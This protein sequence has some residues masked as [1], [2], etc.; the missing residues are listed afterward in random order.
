MGTFWSQTE[1]NS[2]MVSSAQSGWNTTATRRTCVRNS[3]IHIIHCLLQKENKWT[4]MS[5]CGRKV[6]EHETIVIILIKILIVIQYL[7]SLSSG[8]ISNITVDCPVG[9]SLQTALNDILWHSE[10]P[11]NQPLPHDGIIVGYDSST[12]IV[13]SD[14]SFLRRCGYWSG[15]KY[16]RYGYWK[17]ARI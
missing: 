14:I 5:Q 10:P 2:S 8:L 16:T 9:H 12:V 17:H 11:R 15:S 4:L 6:L 13:T 3:G 1:R 7:V